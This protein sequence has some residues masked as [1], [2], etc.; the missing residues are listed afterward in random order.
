MPSLTF[1]SGKLMA[2]WYDSRR[3]NMLSTL[4]CGGGGAS[5]TV[6]QLVARDSII[7]GSQL[8]ATP[9]KPGAVFTTTI[10]DPT[11]APGLRHTIDVYG[12]F[13]DTTSGGAT[14]QLQATRVSQ[15]TYYVDPADNVV[16]QGQFNVPNLP[17]FADGTIPFEGDYIDIAAASIVPNG[18]GGFMFNNAISNSPV[19]HLTWADNRDVIPPSD[20]N[21]KLYVLPNHNLPWSGY[22]Q[23]AF[24][25][26]GSVC[27]TCP[28]QQTACTGYTPGHSGD[29]NQNVYTA[30]FTAG[31]LAQFR[32]NNKP[33]QGFRAP[34][35]SMSATPTAISPTRHRT[36]T[37]STSTRRS[38]AQPA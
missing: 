25:G 10:S 17:M 9:P 24:N 35:R 12:G 13:L 11:T 32:E 38:T 20:S 31:L 5:C 15:Y 33:L 7:A 19:F 34:S 28:T 18:N 1:V 14:P 37:A 30:K 16:K 27:P 29:R 23:S 3:D 2:A 8:A 4:V 21:W 22:P 26:S 6:D 36:G